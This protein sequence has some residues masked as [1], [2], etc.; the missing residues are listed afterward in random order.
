MQESWLYASQLSSLAAGNAPRRHM[1]MCI[2]SLSSQH[3]IAPY[4]SGTSSNSVLL[5]LLAAV[6]VCWGPALPAMS[7]VA[8]GLGQARARLPC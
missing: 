3:L 8:P 7:M 2:S 4:P 5:Q 1:H 6:L